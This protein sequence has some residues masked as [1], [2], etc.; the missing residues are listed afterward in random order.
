MAKAI[1]TTGQV[2][3]LGDGRLACDIGEVYE[4]VDVLLNENI[5]T[6]GLI[7]AGD[8]LKDK[9]RDECLWVKNLPNLN[10]HDD[11][12]NHQKT[13]VVK[14]WVESIS[15]EVGDMHYIPDMS[16]GWAKRNIMD[17]IEYILGKR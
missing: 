15:D 2:I 11:M 12:S 16:K 14:N 3:S 6:I 9:I 10:I 13:T 7:P 1:L 5:S 17:D 4:A 8:Y